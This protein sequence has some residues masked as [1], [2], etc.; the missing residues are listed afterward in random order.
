MLQHMRVGYRIKPTAESKGDTG[1]TQLPRW[2]LA[3]KIAFRFAFVYFP[4]YF[5]YRPEYLPALLIPRLF[6][7]YK[8]L[9]QSIV[10]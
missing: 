9:W 5:L 4:L 6:E 8:L 2:S 1:E 7:K 10:S 3:S